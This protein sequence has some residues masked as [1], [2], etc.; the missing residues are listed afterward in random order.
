LRFKRSRQSVHRAIV[1]DILEQTPPTYLRSGWY[2]GKIDVG[3]HVNVD[4]AGKLTAASISQSSGQM[5]LDQAALLVARES[6]YLP[7]VKNCAPVAG[8]ADITVTFD[9]NH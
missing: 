3:V 2:H 8:S 5:V 7:A 1:A 9:P 4:E 6:V